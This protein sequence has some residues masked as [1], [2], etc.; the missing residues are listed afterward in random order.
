MLHYRLFDC[1]V[2]IMDCELMFVRL[3]RTGQQV[4]N[5]T[6]SHAVLTPARSFT[7][8]TSSKPDPVGKPDTCSSPVSCQVSH[9]T[10][11]PEQ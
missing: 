1:C 2:R 6:P 8:L 5:S 11:Q 9:S 3:C 4:L 10:R 7:S